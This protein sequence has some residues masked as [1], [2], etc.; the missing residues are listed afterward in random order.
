M[1][2]TDLAAEEADTRATLARR[3]RSVAFAALGAGLTV[4]DL[5]DGLI[6]AEEAEGRRQAVPTQ[7]PPL[8]LVPDPG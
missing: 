4:D 3:H 2:T 8:Y 5:L 1:A 6:V 7:R